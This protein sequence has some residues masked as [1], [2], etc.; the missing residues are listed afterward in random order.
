MLI[1]WFCSI[2]KAK[3]KEKEELTENMNKLHIEG[4]SSG[5]GSS[6][7]RRK[8]VI[9]IVV[10]MAGDFAFILFDMLSVGIVF[11]FYNTMLYEQRLA[12]NLICVFR[13]WEDNTHA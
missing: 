1:L 7:F 13:E 6:S 3:D 12:I 8:P 10:G 2:L 9:I 11:H 5:S 4:S